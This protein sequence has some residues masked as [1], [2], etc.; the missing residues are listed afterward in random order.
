[1]I[2]EFSVSNY[3]SI[4]SKQTISFLPNS[5]IRNQADEFLFTKASDDVYLLKLGV[6]YG[7]NASGKS[8]L[9]EAFACLM[10]LILTGRETKSPVYEYRPFLPD[11]KCKNKPSV[12]ELIF[13]TK[14]V[15]YVYTIEITSQVVEKELLCGYPNGRKTTYYSRTF[16][17]DSGTTEVSFSK[18]CHFVN[19]DKKILIGNTLNNISV[20]YAYQ[21][22][23]VSF[24]IFDDVVDYFKN[25]ILPNITPR[26]DLFEWGS[27]K[28]FSD[29]QNISFYQDV[30]RKADFQIANLKVNE[31]NIPVTETLMQRFRERGLPEEIQN[32]IRSRDSLMVRNLLFGH[33]TA[34][35]KEFLL[36]DENESSG[37]RRYFGLAA[38]L[39]ELIDKGHFLCID[40]VETSLHPELVLY[41]LKMF[42]INSKES[43][44]FVSSH[45][46]QMMDSDFMRADMVWFCE[47]GEEGDSE[48]YQL[49][50][51]GLHKNVKATNYY[52]AGRLGAL[53]NLDSPLIEGED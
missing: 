29:Y 28:V 20:L 43:Q 46:H 22:T 23:N 41:Y 10:R 49:Q 4:K 40:E 15:K 3:K 35:G 14:K 11:E 9:I 25:Y 6:L 50:D 42:L 13:F 38:I 30:L 12:F 8:N 19:S 45:V 33:K 1:M 51:F 36:D 53:P 18:E 34:S 16:N 39:K 24:E 32:Q 31:S 44:L 7:Y 52:R 17:K 27:Q 47:K 21:K 48:Y 5:K 26:V 37:T 2:Q